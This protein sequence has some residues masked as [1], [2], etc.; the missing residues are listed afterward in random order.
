MLFLVKLR[1]RQA[2]VPQ[3]GH[4]AVHRLQRALSRASR[5]G[6]IQRAWGLPGGGHVLLM[7]AKS[8]AHL[9]ALL[10]KHPLW[11]TSDVE[12]EPLVSIEDT[13]LTHLAIASGIDPS[14]INYAP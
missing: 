14:T 13:F 6:A 9:G 11:A 10:R 12:I 8:H 7:K 5:S 1:P 3:G 2:T 4:E